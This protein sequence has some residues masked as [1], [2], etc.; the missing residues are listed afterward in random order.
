[1]AKLNRKIDIEK[2]GQGGRSQSGQRK[3]TSIPGQR[4]F[5]KVFQRKRLP[6]KLVVKLNRERLFGCCCSSVSDF[7]A[8]A[9][10]LL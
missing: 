9:V 5:E 2:S 4:K 8:V 6:S 7:S 3:S 10:L 1:M